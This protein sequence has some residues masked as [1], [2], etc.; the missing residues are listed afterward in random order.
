M[1]GKKQDEYEKKVLNSRLYRSGD[2]FTLS[3]ILGIVDISS[4]Y[5]R[6]VLF[7][8][9]N[10]GLLRQ[11]DSETCI[12]YSSSSPARRLLKSRLASYEPPAVGVERKVNPWIRASARQERANAVGQ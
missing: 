12:S 5:A 7:G 9:V 8:L 6:S 10:D 4:S 11:I 3:D 1:R 2:S